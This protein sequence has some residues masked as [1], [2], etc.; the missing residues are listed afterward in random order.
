MSRIASDGA[1]LLL[2]VR[3]TPGASKD[4]VEGWR[5][6]ADGA[7]HLAVRVRAVPE[8]GKANTALIALMAKHLGLPKRDL[9]VI[10]GATSR[11]KTVRIEAEGPA[12]ARIRSLLESSSD[13]C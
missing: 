9:D 13:E 1:G 6:S 12:Q 11:L 2:P 4:A 3:L 5:Q 7:W 8:K 10:R